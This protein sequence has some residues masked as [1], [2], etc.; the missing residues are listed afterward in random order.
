MQRYQRVTY[1]TRC[2]I[3]GFL[4]TKISISEIARLTGYHKSTIYREIKRNRV[5][6][7]YHAY[8]ANILALE[9]FKFC[10]KKLILQGSAKE[11]VVSKLSQGW[12]PEQ[13][14]GRC[15]SEGVLKVSTETIYK[16]IR[17]QH[18]LGAMPIDLGLRRYK[19]KGAGRIR[20]KQFRPEWMKSIHERPKDVHQRIHFGH[21]ERDTMYARN[22]KLLLVCLE[23]KSRFIKIQKA[24]E[25]VSVFL[26][27]QTK[28][29]LESTNT[30]V[31]SITN[32]NGSEFKDGFNFKVPV[33]YCDPRKP[34]Q[35]GSVEN[36]IGLL[37]QY[38]KRTT[39]LDTLTPEKIREL[40]DKIN[41]R[42]RKILNYQTPYEILYG[43]RVALVS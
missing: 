20:A 38:I 34:Q 35:R 17:Q 16:F 4:K 14:S 12:S 21:W 3:F 24:H 10:R 23:R 32:D 37:R 15:K 30:E 2:Q 28:H 7:V 6:A 8:A 31:K 40:E 13:V 43:K 41:L 9:R 42:P 19:K 1:E 26:S 22:R 36:A 39:D 25:P 11:L 27:D 29:L 18:K 5:E 33:F